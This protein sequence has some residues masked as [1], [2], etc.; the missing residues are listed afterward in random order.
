MDKKQYVLESESYGVGRKH[1]DGYYTGD[2]YIFQGEKYAVCDTDFE[3]AKKYTSLKR[4]EKAKEALN[5]KVV[6]YDF[7]VKEI[8]P[9]KN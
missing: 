7:E 1:F 6:N 2:T 5:E 8:C 9:I 3:K 4:A